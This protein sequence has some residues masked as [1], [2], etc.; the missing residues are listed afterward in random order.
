MANHMSLQSHTQNG[1]TECAPA[2][3]LH[4]PMSVDICLWSAASVYSFVIITSGD[5]KS[6]LLHCGDVFS[7]PQATDEAKE[8]QEEGELIEVLPE[9]TDEELLAQ[10]GLELEQQ[11]ADLTASDELPAGIMQQWAE[12]ELRRDREQW[13][14]RRELPDQAMD[15]EEED[16]GDDAGEVLESRDIKGSMLGPCELIMSIN[17]QKFPLEYFSTWKLCPDFIILM[18]TFISSRDC[19]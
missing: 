4:V 6:T 8:E 15:E 2:C 12:E 11:M 16:R 5:S 7:V 9:P 10:L 18:Q 3:I 19:T 1:K 17:A 14:P 13:Q